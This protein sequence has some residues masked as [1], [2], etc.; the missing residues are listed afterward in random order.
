MKTLGLIVA[1]LLILA[2][3]LAGGGTYLFYH[4]G[5]DLPDHKQLAAYEPATVTRIHAGDGRLMAEYAVEKRVFVPLVAL[6]QDVIDAFLAAEDKNFYQHFGVDLISVARAIIKNIGNL[7]GDRRLIGAS[8]ITQQVAKN[9][10]LTNEMSL[11]RK[12]KEAILALRIER[13]FTKDRILELYLNEI[14]LGFGSYGVAAAA[15]NYFNK[16]LDELTLAE[17]AYLAA[18]PKA[19]NNY[20]PIYRNKAGVARRNWVISRMLEDGL[21]TAAEASVASAKPLAVRSREATEMVEAGYFTEEV[22]RWLYERYGERGLYKGGLSVR[23]TLDPVMQ[24][25]ADKMLRRG[26]L[27]YDR[28]HGWRGPLSRMEV[29]TNWPGQLAKFE[30]PPSPDSWRIALVLDVHLDGVE[31]GLADGQ[32]GFVPLDE[33]TW[34]RQPVGER[35]VGPEV[36]QASDVLAQGDIVFVEPMAHGTGRIYGLRQVPEVGGA[37]VAIDPHNGRVLAMSGGFNFAESQFNRVTQARRQ[38]GSAF[39]P[40]VYLAALDSGFTPATTVL[41]A[42]FVVDQGAELGKWKP[43]NYSQKFYGPSPLRLGLEKSRN[44]MTVRIAQTVGMDRVVDYARRFNINANLPPVPAMALGAG[45]TTLL[46]LTAAY[47]ML[48][49]GGRRIEPATIERIQDRNGKVI[50]RRD[51]RTCN[52]CASLGWADQPPPRL[53]DKREQLADPRTTYQVVSMLEGVVQRGTGRS[54]REVGRPL[55]GKTGTTNEFRDAWFIGFTPDLAVGVYV[56]FDR[57]QTLGR[58]ESGGKVAAPIF[59]DFMKKVL[60]DTP[61]V[62]FRV[63]PGIRFVRVDPK[64]GVPAQPGTR[65]T[66]IEA[67]LADSKLPSQRQTVRQG[68]GV[69]VGGLY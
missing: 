12:I 8:T 64:T 51:R 25:T 16:S 56:G 28:R 21:I 57:P 54:V 61:A 6:P 13:T 44:V 5:R 67:F 10:L 62:P 53:P 27:A 43:E 34:A 58:R 30:P 1:G 49:N 45:E 66:I 2:A 14:Y 40:F 65:N 37:L 35:A 20:H 31:I 68:N 4:Y 32:G 15:L 22:R 52:A 41:D 23:T 69:D 7:R 9:F 47:A 50:H 3:V 46:R 11:T 18:L 42:P 24:A 17:M 48:V 60:A 26:L 33:L 38:P 29:T 63:P 36:T 55:A 39:K 59:R 19:P